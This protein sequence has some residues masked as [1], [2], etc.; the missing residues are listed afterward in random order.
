MLLYKVR[1]KIYLVYLN[2]HAVTDE[3]SLENEI[4]RSENAYLQCI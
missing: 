3:K 2:N 1:L 4:V